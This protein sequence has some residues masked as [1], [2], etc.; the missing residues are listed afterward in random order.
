MISIY[1]NHNERKKYVC[2]QII[3]DLTFKNHA[4]SMSPDLKRKKKLKPKFVYAAKTPKVT[5]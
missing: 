2:N 3:L 1:L 4:K 5:F